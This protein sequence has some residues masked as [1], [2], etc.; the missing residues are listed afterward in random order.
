MAGTTSGTTTP[1]LFT[2][3][4][5]SRESPN[6]RTLAFRRL[7]PPLPARTTG[8]LTTHLLLICFPILIRACC[9][10]ISS[11]AGLVTSSGAP[12]TSS[13]PTLKRKRLH[14][15]YN[16]AIHGNYDP[17]AD[18]ARESDSDEEEEA[19]AAGA[20]ASGL[21]KPG[22]NDYSTHAPF[23][24]FTGKFQPGMNPEYHNDENKSKRQMNA[25]FDVDAAA[26]SHDGRSLKE[27]RRNKK[28]SKKELKAFKQ[29]AAEKKRE[30]ARNWLT[31]D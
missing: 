5:V 12:G 18:Y 16:P 11:A 3:T 1:K 30:K 28:L 14:G 25:F 23:N 15:G 27:E 17:K 29:K 24:R 7:L 8:L 19:P 13:P 26:N 21:P 20:G 6:G 10:H 9:S 31:R 2:S 4:I 22:D